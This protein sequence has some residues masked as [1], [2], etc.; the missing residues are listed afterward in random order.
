MPETSVS[1]WE[2]GGTLENVPFRI[3]L[4]GVSV[5]HRNS[6]LLTRSLQSSVRVHDVQTRPGGIYAV[7]FTF[8]WVG[9]QPAQ[10]RIVSGA[11]EVLATCNLAQDLSYQ[12]VEQHCDAPVSMSEGQIDVRLEIVSGVQMELGRVVVRRSH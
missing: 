7:R 3:Q 12:A 8:S 2:L 6:V 1:P 4:V 5:S 9:P 10:V 11:S